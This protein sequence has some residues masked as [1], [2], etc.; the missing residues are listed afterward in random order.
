MAE[1]PPRVSQVLGLATGIIFVASCVV[2]QVLSRQPVTSAF[3][4]L[5]GVVGLGG[6][7]LVIF[8][9]RLLARSR[10]SRRN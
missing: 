5:W 3:R 10:S 7:V 6:L 4:L 2:V 8:W 1:P 9:G